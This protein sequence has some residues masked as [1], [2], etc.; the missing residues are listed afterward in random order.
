VN[1]GPERRFDPH[2]RSLLTVRDLPRFSGDS[3]FDRIGRAVCSAECLPR[4]ELFESWEVAR[5]ARRKLRG[6]RVLDLAGGHG[7]TA[8]LALVLDATSESAVVV[9][10]RI[11][12]SAQTLA[13]ALDESF[14]RLSG[15]VELRESDLDA[16]EVARGDL[17][18][19]VHACGALTDAV[20]DRVV[21]AGARLAALPC[22]HD[23]STCDTGGLDAWLDVGTAIDAVRATRL[24]ASGFTVKLERI[25]ATITPK[26]RLILAWPDSPGLGA[27]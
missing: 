16:V 10:R 18:L 9:D 1:E 24:R 11:P 14:P 20:I 8:R 12:K 25:P 23:T 19:A 27:A 26:N 13:D 7:L 2:S 6:G 3:L 22:C 21:G 17:V 5:R 15:R 4:K